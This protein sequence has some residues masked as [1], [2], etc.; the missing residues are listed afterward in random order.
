MTQKKF[1][2]HQKKFFDVDSFKLNDYKKDCSF[3]IL[4]I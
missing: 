3:R 2:N 4:I 1:K